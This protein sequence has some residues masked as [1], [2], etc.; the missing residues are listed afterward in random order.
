MLNLVEMWERLAYFS[1]RGVIGIYIM[2]ADDPGGLQLTA[3]I[4]GTIFAWWFLVQSVLPTVTGGFADRYGYKRVLGGSVLTNALGYTLM[5]FARGPWSFFAAVMVLATGTAFFKP[6]LQGSIAHNLGKANASVGW[7]IFYWVVNIGAA[8]GPV[9]ATWVLG[10]HSAV[11][12]QHLFLASAGVTLLNLGMLFTF[13]DVPSGAERTH[14]LWAVLRATIG[15][16]LEPRLLTWLVIM[17]GFWL[18]MF[19]LWDLHPN[20]IVDWVDSS[21]IAERLSFLPESIHRRFF[22]VP[23]ARGLQVP[24]QMLLNANA[25]LILLCVVPMS[26][27]VRRMRALSA[28]VIGMIGAVTGILVSGLTSSGWILLLG[29]ACF[30][31][32]EMLIGPK[33]QHYLGLI[34]PP[35]RKALYMGYTNI[36]FGVGGFLGSEMAGRLYGRFGEKATLALR[37]LVEHSGRPWDGRISGLEAAAGVPRNAALGRLQEALGL[38]A[39]QATRLLWETYHPQLWIWIPFAIIGVISGVALACYGRAA[40]RWVDLDA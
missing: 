22:A 25:A 15:H 28:M 4:K 7:G 9:L 1:V 5:A 26:W 19:Q 34:A 40:R 35:D 12:W 36:P 17:S 16:V 18:M 20:F 33:M 10:G 31:M 32:G 24:Q 37:Y 6:A 27:L 29:I 13:R 21:M 11:E 2:Q 3:Q 14:G 30:S 39:A 8:V 38:D 23:T